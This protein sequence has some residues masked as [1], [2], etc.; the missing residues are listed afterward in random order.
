MNNKEKFDFYLDKLYREIGSNGVNEQDKTVKL[1]NPKLNKEGGARTI[2]ENFGSTAVKLKR[3][4]EHLQTFYAN[5]LSTDCN[6]RKNDPNDPSTFKLVI[7]GKGRYA[8][9]GII[10][11]LQSY[12]NTFVQCKVCKSMNTVLLKEQRQ[13]HVECKDC[14]SKLC[15]QV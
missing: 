13:Y 6:I 11:I 10:K 2:W 8:K 14:F 9:S 4:I 5:E 12:I 1:H 7:R 3:P 15:C